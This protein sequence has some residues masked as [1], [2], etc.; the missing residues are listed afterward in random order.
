MKRGVSRMVRLGLPLVVVAAALLSAQAM[1]QS[2]RT[3]VGRF[4]TPVFDGDQIY[5]PTSLDVGADGHIVV[6]A[7]V[8][9]NPYTVSSTM[10]ARFDGTGR[11]LWERNPTGR[12]D[13]VSTMLARAAPGGDTMVLH[14]E[15]PNEQPQLVLLRLA[16]SGKELWRRQLGPG[17][18]SDLLVEND[19]A[20]VISGSA[21]RE[22]GN[23]FDALVMRVTGDGKTAWR[24][25]VPGDKP[26][27][28][29][30]ADLLR[31]TA[32]K[33]YIAGG[34]ADIAYADANVSASRGLLV[35]LGSDGQIQ[36]RRSF[37]SG[38][39]LTM[40]SGI[41]GSGP[42]TFVLT[43]TES[44]GGAQFFELSRVQD[45]GN[46]SWTR[47]LPGP[48]DQEIND[49]ASGPNG[50]VVLAGSEPNG[51]SRVAVLIVLDQDGI[52]RQRVNYRG[53]KMRRAL[54][55][56]AYPTGGYAVLFEGASPSSDSTLYLARVDTNGRF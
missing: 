3:A 21:K 48:A 25:Q 38:A 56:H 6:A 5:S 17:A 14:D 24:R 19:G 41:A 51:D 2:Q 36:W 34:L 28:G 12:A 39:T 20:A 40:V 18:P 26:D 30:T 1:G 52:E 29:N 49:I 9:A 23:A 11:K 45:N 55:L 35:K 27:G 46:V 42:D 32:A 43:L 13:L 33:Q 16:V 44:S 54:S 50:G 37:G 47:P 7:V 31:S 4:L 22:K 10:V 8:P 15:S 53:Y